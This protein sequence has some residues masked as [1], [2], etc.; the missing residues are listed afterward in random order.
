MII[1]DRTRLTGLLININLKQQIFCCFFHVLI[2][3]LII[4][5]FVKII[6]DFE[7]E[8][9]DMTNNKIIKY[10]IYAIIIFSP[11]FYF[12]AYAAGV[13][14]F[15]LLIKNDLKYIKYIIVKQRILVFIVAALLLSTLFSKVPG[16]SLLVD[17]VILLHLMIYIAIVK[18]VS[19]ENI[20][21]IFRLL[22]ILAILIC[23]YGIYQY[24]TGDLNIEKSWTD[25]IAFGNLT[26]I[27]STLRNPNIFAAYLTFNICYSIAYFLK[28][29]ADVY[30]AINIILSS[31]CLILTYSRGGF[32]ALAVAMLFIAI[33]FREVKTIYYLIV[34]FFLYFG[35]DFIQSTYRG[36][37]SKLAVDSSSM[38][39]LEIWKASWELF[40]GNIIFGSGP[41]SVAMLLSYSS[42]KLK[43]I[44]MHSHNISLYM[45]AET[46]LFG[47]ATFI[48][49]VISE[50][51]KVLF[52]WTKQ[53]DIEYL[54][55]LV[56]FGASLTAMLAHG[57]IDCA[58][59]IPSRSLIFLVYLALFPS[60]YLKGF[61]NK[62]TDII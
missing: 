35:F 7:V 27:Y 22:N 54:Y 14:A 55:I 61:F 6:K 60:L 15:I 9:I 43:G 23:I 58:V 36:D 5:D 39:R 62:D 2:Y 47:F 49:L 21:N 4:R 11:T 3:L 46:G 34:M 17:I 53:R 29:K 44:I 32:F 40:K 56:G 1:H 12:G 30:V 45:L 28:K 13:L 25:E 10:L 52:I 50:M 38:Y 20:D 48:F 42:D 19:R 26:R 8:E 18:W 51:K 33:V 59:F 16:Y 37:L 31:I 57:I 41:G 24:V